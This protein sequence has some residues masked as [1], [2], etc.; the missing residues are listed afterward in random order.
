MKLNESFPEIYQLQVQEAEGTGGTT[1]DKS[2]C[3]FGCSHIIVIHEFEYCE[4]ADFEVHFDRE[5]L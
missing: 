1:I 4:G 3:N 2:G 5:L